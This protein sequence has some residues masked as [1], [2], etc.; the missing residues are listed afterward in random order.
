LVGS[1]QPEGGVLRLELKAK[2]LS[3][4]YNKIVVFFDPKRKLPLAQ[5]MFSLSGKLIKTIEY[6][7]RVQSDNTLYMSEMIIK[8]ELMGNSF[9]KM[10]YENC[11]RR[12]NRP[13]VFFSLG[14]LK[15]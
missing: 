9:T 7:Y 15:Q 8:D 10:Y 6:I 14:S 4:S 3:V 12:Q 1:E 13:D 5:E 2:S 11:K